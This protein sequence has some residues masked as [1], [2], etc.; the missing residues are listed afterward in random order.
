MM[1][2]HWYWWIS[3]SLL[4]SVQKASSMPELVSGRQNVPTPAGAAGNTMV[5]DISSDNRLILI[6]S[7]APNLVAP[8]TSGEVNLFLVN[9]ETEV[10]THISRGLDGHGAD[11]P[12]LSA[13][14]SH[15]AG[16]V[17]FESRARNLTP[18]PVS[19]AGD[20]FAYDVETGVTRLVSVNR[21]GTG[22]G[23]GRSFEA[24]LTP[25]GRYVAFVS[26]ADDLVEGDDNGADDIFRR[27]LWE[28]TTQLVTVSWTG[29]G[30]A[31]AAFQDASHSPSISADGRYVAFASV[32]GLVLGTPLTGRPQQVYVRDLELG[33]NVVISVAVNGQPTRLGSSQSPAI[34]GDKVYFLSAARDLTTEQLN[35]T[36]LY[37]R[38]IIGGTTLRASAPPESALHV[39]DEFQLQGEGA[40]IAYSFGGGANVVRLRDEAAATDRVITLNTNGAPPS[41]RVLEFQLSTDGRRLAFVS[42]ARDLVPDEAGGKSQ[43]YLT[44]LTSP[45][46][47]LIS[48]SGTG[49]AGSEDC[50]NL[51]ASGD[52]TKVAFSAWDGNLVPRDNNRALDAFF[53]D[54]TTD[55]VVIL[56]VG[57]EAEVSETSPAPSGLGLLDV[58]GDG[59]YV[60]FTSMAEDLV[61]ND[62]NGAVDVFLRDREKSVIMPISFT[63]LGQSANGP[64]WGAVM[65]PDARFVA[66][67]S[68]ATDLAGTDTNQT[69]D[70]YLRDVAEGTNFMVSQALDGQAGGEVDWDLPLV[71]SADGRWVGFVS[72]S[73]NMTEGDT[74]GTPDFFLRDRIEETTYRVPP[75][76]G[77]FWAT[78]D[79]PLLVTREG[80]VFYRGGPVGGVFSATPGSTSPVE[81]IAAVTGL[82]AITPDGRWIAYATGAVQSAQSLWLLDTSVGP[83]IELIDAPTGLFPN[84][85]QARL[86]LSADGRRVTFSTRAALL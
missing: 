49:E 3:L 71:L 37:S 64:S 23:H 44:D 75:P 83:P 48:R 2:L 25:D 35:T 85:E 63:S 42:A 24:V 30:S 20:L 43:V 77:S 22:G 76:P 26:Q 33:T 13:F 15:D 82:P 72:S 60:L 8:A 31:A 61:E 29:I 80:Q 1:I 58:S 57:A 4:L 66:F 10:F 47:R 40:W 45:G 54:A 55:E 69:I 18:D 21:Q 62:T 52:L 78:T 46:N 74:A 11:G 86:G 56:S 68:L 53:W 73:R 34:A 81:T 6:V 5:V 36:V 16:W 84:Q 27:D 65:T 9:R 70:V 79:F 39:V 51:V 17:V 7:D 67:Y 28:Q 59:R 41:A 32:A 12:T 14:L 38:P 19:G 50:Q